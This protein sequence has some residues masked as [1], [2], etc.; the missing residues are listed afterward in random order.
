MCWV[1]RAA[2]W[3][4]S[5]SLLACRQLRIDFLLFGVHV[6]SGTTRLTDPKA[7]PTQHE[8]PMAAINLYRIYLCCVLTAVTSLA[9][10][11]SKDGVIPLSGPGLTNFTGRDGSGYWDSDLG[12]PLVHNGT[13]WLLEGDVLG[14]IPHRR[15]PSAIGR[16]S[17]RGGANWET[18]ADGLP[19][20]VFPLLAE[21]T[22]PAGAIWL[23]GLGPNG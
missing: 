12:L 19:I 18:A 5:I 1:H 8:L 7:W 22:V 15:I 13:M 14:N 23:P 4:A 20:P 6:S 21:S 11:I 2:I 16:R 17:T 3:R 9:L 10:E